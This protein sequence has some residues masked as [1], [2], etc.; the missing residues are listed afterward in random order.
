MALA[1]S[2]L[3]SPQ[4]I[5]RVNAA[6]SEALSYD[7]ETATAA[8]HNLPAYLT[9]HHPDVLSAMQASGLDVVDMGR[10]CLNVARNLK[11]RATR[12]SLHDLP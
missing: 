10:K 4:R 5:E 6:P 2:G 8:F 7:E 3:A 9:R 11:A 12:R 1:S